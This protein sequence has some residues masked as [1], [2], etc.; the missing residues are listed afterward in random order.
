MALVRERDLETRLRTKVNQTGCRCLKFVSPGCTG[1]PDRIILVPGGQVC[2]VEM[3]APGKAERPRQ[4]IVQAWLRKLDFTVFSSVD[5][6]EKI[7]EVVSWC[8]ERT[9]KEGG[10]DE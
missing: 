4:R 5:S 7:T 2:F 9:K 1:V 10:A 8:K 3:K 6:A